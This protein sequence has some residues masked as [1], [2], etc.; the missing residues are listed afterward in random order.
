MLCHVINL[1]LLDTENE[2]TMFLRNV[3]QSK[4]VSTQRL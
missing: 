2:D 3:C 1:E 4:E